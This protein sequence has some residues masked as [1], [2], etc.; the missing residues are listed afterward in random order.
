M[1]SRDIFG[2]PTGIQQIEEERRYS[3]PGFVLPSAETDETVEEEQ[4][5]PRGFVGL[6]VFLILIV[7][8]LASRCFILEVTQG[9]ANRALAQGNSLRIL[10]LQPNRGLIEDY[11]GT[12]LA[13]N[14]RQLALAINPQTLP[15][16][17]A[18]RE[19]V[20]NLLK[21]KAGIDDKT[22]RLIE[23]N[24]LKSPDIF[25]IKTN[26]SQDE[27]LLYKEWFTTI[28]G[29][30]FQEVPIRRYADYPS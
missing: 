4:Q 22:I 28:P 30:V 7:T 2:N 10:T 6:T 29:V 12:V 27:S 13:Q 26:L 24:R 8:I 5:K 16:K 15:A 11:T 25:P 14:T 23:D 19:K 3:D 21:A 17:K 18:D 9:S 1:S 20:Y